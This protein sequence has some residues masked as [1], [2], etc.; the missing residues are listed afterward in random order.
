MRGMPPPHSSALRRGRRSCASQVY[1]VTFTTY[2]RL[3]HFGNWD[4]AW[5]MARTLASPA[6]WADSR[7]LCWVLMPDHW[8]GIL[9]LGRIDSL[10]RNIGRAKALAA[11]EWRTR[12][13]WAK[14]FHD[15]LLT[16]ER[17]LLAASRYVVE[18]P[19]KAGLAAHPGTYPFWD[20]WW[21]PDPSPVVG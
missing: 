5:P 21:L 2:R 7:L 19:V 20:A 3:R 17:G 10:P 4:N 8:H 18:N 13:P 14:G 11:R 6:A 1:I 16:S 12:S 15:R 9:Q